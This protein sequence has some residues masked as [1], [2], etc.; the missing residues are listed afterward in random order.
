[1]G[2]LMVIAVSVDDGTIQPTLECED[3][4]ITL[5]PNAPPRVVGCVNSDDFDQWV[6]SLRKDGKI[7]LPS[8]HSEYQHLYAGGISPTH[9]GVILHTHNSPGQVCVPYHGTLLCYP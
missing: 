7:E 6:A 9:V 1:M 8:V 3:G 5:D 4:S 2:Q